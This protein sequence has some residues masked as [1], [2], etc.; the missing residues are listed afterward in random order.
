MNPNKG[1]TREWLSFLGALGAEACLFAVF[2][3]A[4]PVL[5]SVP[6]AHFGT[7][8]AQSD[9]TTAF[10]AVIRLGGLMVS[11][12]LVLTSLLY[13]LA[14]L[15]GSARA[16]RSTGWM[17]LPAVRKLLDGAA[18]AAILVSAVTASAGGAS[19]ASAPPTTVAIPLHPDRDVTPPTIGA[20]LAVAAGHVSHPGLA[21]HPMPATAG[22]GFDPS[23][24]SPSNGFAGL[25]PGTKV[26]VVEPGDCLSIIA[27]AHLGDWRR[28]TEID[29]L[30]HGRPQ[31]DG[32]SLLDDHWIYPSWVL[33]MPPDATDT[34][35]VR[36]P[37]TAG[38]AGAST[39]APGSGRRLRRPPRSGAARSTRRASRCRPRPPRAAPPTLATP[40]R[41]PATTASRWRRWRE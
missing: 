30:N 16:M 13:A 22:P 39:P 7:W 34:L 26:Y 23:A 9:A 35:V 40:M 32:R 27:E 28:D 15:S 17:A 6:L 21:E 14:A 24:P 5:G 3:L 31:A 1:T 8:L 10:L 25:A 29:A 18:G 38:I 41:R 37:A 20:G 4:A 12:W 11:A 33:V 19:A 2:Y 36:D